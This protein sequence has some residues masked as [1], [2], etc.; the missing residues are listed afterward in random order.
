MRVEGKASKR[1]REKRI[2]KQKGKELKIALQQI[3]NKH[4]LRQA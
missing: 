2:L 4:I 1:K 3:D